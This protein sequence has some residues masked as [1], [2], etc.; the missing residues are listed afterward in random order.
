MRIILIRH[1]EPDYEHD[2]L[3]EK[4]FREAALLARRAAGWQVDDVYVSPLG[5]AQATAQPLLQALGKTA[6]TLPWLQEFRGRIRDD[7]PEGSTIP[8]DFLPSEW[9][10]C[11]EQ[12]D[13]DR[14]STAAPME[15]ADGQPTPA[16]VYAETCAGLDALLA[17]Y[18]YDRQGRIYAVRA[19]S[20]ATIVCVCHMAISCAMLS[21]LLNIPFLPLIQGL[22]L[23][24][25]SITVLNTE[26]R[27]PGTAAFRCQAIGDASHLRTAGEPLS[28]SGSFAPLFLG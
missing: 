16:Q 27:E 23:P 18:G 21:H 25:S 20:D 19:H 4:G 9:T 5:R 11:E 3:T 10:A 17:R 12:Y 2:S 28:A 7:G 26:E 24:P 15:P 8:W 22:F 13:V 14:W 1:A 6:Q